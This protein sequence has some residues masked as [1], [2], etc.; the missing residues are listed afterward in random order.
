MP[1]WEKF[2]CDC[3]DYLNEKFRKYANFTHLGGSDSTTS[4]IL[5]EPKSNNKSPFYIDAKKAPAQCGQFVLSPNMQTRRFEYSKKNKSPANIYTDK[6]AN[7]MNC[8]FDEFLDAGTAGKNIYMNEP[9]V[10]SSWIINNFQNHNT[11]FIITNGFT[12]LPICDLKLHFTVSAKCRTKKSGSGAAGKK[13]I[14]SL[15]EYI[16]SNNY[17]ME[18]FDIQ[19]NKLFIK[20]SKNLK[21]EKITVNEKEFIFSPQNGEYELRKL[22]NTK[23]ANVIFSIDKKE[24]VSGMSDNDFIN[25][26]I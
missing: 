23:N 17:E 11:K 9:D 22:S 19:K 16:K 10:F 25:A 26:L 18:S 5:V 4:D 14:Y 15:I 21:N 13:Y 8:R 12:I 7:Y 1:N 6:I 20:S 2:E 24:S 3:T